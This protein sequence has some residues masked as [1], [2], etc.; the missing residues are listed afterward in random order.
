MAPELL[1]T[2]TTKRNVIEMQN[3]DIYSFGIILYEILSRKE[4]FEDDTDVL[5]FEGMQRQILYA[6]LY[7]M[8]VK[9]I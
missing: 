3:A 8:I 6:A 2:P 7:T 9:K 4:P 5:F 1:R